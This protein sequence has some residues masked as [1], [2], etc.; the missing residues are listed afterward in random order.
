MIHTEVPKLIIKGAREVKK[1]RHLYVAQRVNMICN[2][3]FAN[4]PIEQNVPACKYK[5]IKG[6]GMV[7]VIAVQKNKK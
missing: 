5:N 1:K 4:K 3:T 6:G 7:G 2:T